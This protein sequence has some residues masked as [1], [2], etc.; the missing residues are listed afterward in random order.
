MFAPE[1]FNT[2]LRSR[3]PNRLATTNQIN[4]LIAAFSS[5]HDGLP[6]DAEGISLDANC[7]ITGDED[8]YGKYTCDAYESSNNLFDPSRPVQSTDIEGER[9]FAD[10]I[11]VNLKENGKSTHALTA[12]SDSD[13]V[14]YE[15][16][17]RGFSSE[18][19]PRAVFITNGI[20]IKLCPT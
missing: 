17:L 19:P 18:T 16:R 14:Y 10:A 1:N 4:D 2:L 12:V 8:G 15:A 5:I 13:Q 3:T 7:K 6:E 20:A 11:L 9:I